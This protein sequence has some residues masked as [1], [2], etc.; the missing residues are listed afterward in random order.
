MAIKP[1]GKPCLIREQIIEDPVSE[2]TLQF[3]A[4]DNGT[5]RL[6]IYGDLPFGNREFIFDENGELGGTG[7]ALAGRCQATWLRN[8]DN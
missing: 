1:T 2:L 5:V 3:E 6:C 8:V 7:T 4:F